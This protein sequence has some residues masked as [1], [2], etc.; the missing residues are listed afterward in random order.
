MEERAAERP[1]TEVGGMLFGKFEKEDG[2]VVD[3]RVER[4]VNVPDD[5]G[6]HQATYFSINDSFMSEVVDEYI[7]PYTY[8]GNWHSHLGYGG[9]SSGDHKQVSKFFK[10]NPDRD[11]L[12]AVI[13][14]RDGGIRDP[15]YATYIELYER[16]RDD[17]SEFHINKITG[18]ETIEHPPERTVDEGLDG[19]NATEDD[20]L[21]RMEAD[22]STLDLNDGLASD[23]SELASELVTELDPVDKNGVGTVYQN[24]R[25]EPETILLVPL[26]LG[27][28]SEDSESASKIEQ[29]MDE[30]SKSLQVTPSTIP[31]SSQQAG[32]LSVFLSISIPGSYPEGDIYVDVKSRDQTVQATIMRTSCAE[33]SASPR[34]FR[35]QIQ[36]MLDEDI[37]KFLAQSI[38]QLL[39]TRGGDDS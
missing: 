38:D 26:E 23:I 20:L 21:E 30:V 2:Q 11:Y 8:L 15:E 10:E 37:D 16:K 25:E 14:D 17:S 24:P 19:G 34:E 31:D 33:L 6:V 4:V 27:T 5:Q 3:V 12:I 9:P 35:N 32:P 13:Q 18:V 28:E 29:A 39:V 7:P 36:T 1:Q 22:L